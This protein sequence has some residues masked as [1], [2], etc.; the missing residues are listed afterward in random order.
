MAPILGRVAL[1]SFLYT[2]G[3]AQLP[4]ACSCQNEAYD[5]FQCYT[6]VKASYR[7]GTEL[8]TPFCNLLFS[9]S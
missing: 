5:L 2:A 3:S 4:L 9:L 8:G 6:H 1:K 7:G